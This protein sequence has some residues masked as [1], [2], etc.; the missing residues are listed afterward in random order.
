MTGSPQALPPVLCRRRLGDVHLLPHVRDLPSG[1]AGGV[2]RFFFLTL[3]Q[4]A[5]VLLR[6]VA[7]GVAGPRMMEDVARL[8][9]LSVARLLK[10]EVLGEVG[11]VVADAQP[12]DERRR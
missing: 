2:L 12:G 10:D 5:P 6:G 9:V 11:A 7:G 8:E 4:R 3:A 1:Q